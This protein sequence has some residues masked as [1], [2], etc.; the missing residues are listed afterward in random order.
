MSLFSKFEIH[1]LH[2]IPEIQHKRFRRWLIQRSGADSPAVI[3]PVAAR[4]RCGPN[5]ELD[6]VCRRLEL[7]SPP[8]PAHTPPQ[9]DPAVASGVRSYTEAVG[10]QN[11]A[12]THVSRARAWPDTEKPPEQKAQLVWRAAGRADG[13]IQQVGSEERRHGLQPF[14]V[15]NK[16]GVGLQRKSVMML[17]APS[18]LNDYYASVLDCSCDGMVALALGSSVHLW[19][20]ETHEV[21]GHLEPNPD[22][23][24]PHR[25]APSVSC[26]CWS[27]DG[28]VLCIGNRRGGMQVTSLEMRLWDVDHKQSIRYLHSHLSSVGALSWKQQLLTSGSALGHIHHL[29]PRAP[30]PVIGVASQKGGVCNLQ[31]SPGDDW[32]ASGS[33]EGLLHIWDSDITGPKGPQQPIMTMEQPSAVKALGWCPWQREVIA[34][35]GGWKDGEL[36]VWDTRSG[37]CLTSVNTNSQICSLRWAE[38]KRY[39]VTG[40]GLPHHQVTSWAWEFPSLR[41]IHQLT[42]HSHRVL[43]LAI[44]PDNSHVFSAA[45]DQRLHVWDL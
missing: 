31:W 27:R 20:S 18:L 36:R 6:T 26:L 13:R 8:R 43:H 28:R 33:P 2:N 32:L 1:K 5:F 11:T 34:T 44:N 39:L 37:S 35:G 10:P 4:W 3:P 24:R 21:V 23:S 7:D 14:A 25:Q 41:R 22:A 12:H 16:A 19:N 45:A 15:L 42:G 30:A 38:K 17:G 40:H 9:G 29:D